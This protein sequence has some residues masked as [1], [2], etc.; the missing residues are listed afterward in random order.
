MGVPGLLRNLLS[1][2]QGVIDRPIHSQQTV[3]KSLFIDFNNMIYGAYRTVVAQTVKSEPSH[4]TDAT[5]GNIQTA[6]INQ[7]IADTKQIINIVNPSVLLYIA[8]DGPAPFAKIAHRGGNAATAL[9]RN[10]PYPPPTA[11][12]QQTKQP[13]YPFSLLKRIVAMGPPPFPT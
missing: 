7:I 8:I 6:I 13:R 12:N 11:T 3:Y 9:G 1:H 4:Q 5:A 2:Y 10:A